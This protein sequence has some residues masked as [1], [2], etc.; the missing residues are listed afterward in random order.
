MGWTRTALVRLQHETERECIERHL[1]SLIIDDARVKRAFPIQTTFPSNILHSASA[2]WMAVEDGD[3]MTARMF[4]CEHWSYGSFGV[5]VEVTD[6]P[7]WH[8]PAVPPP[9]ELIEYLD[10]H[11]MPRHWPVSVA[12][13][14]RT[15]R[16]SMA[17][18]MAV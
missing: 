16:D 17:R 7:E 18:L 8:K 14:V 10:Q 13:Q 12:Q 2:L 15:W 4:L 5:M 9:V 6:M 11:G 1:T 3:G